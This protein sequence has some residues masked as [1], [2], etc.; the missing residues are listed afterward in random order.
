MLI[1]IWSKSRMINPIDS[2]VDK[3][4][5]YKVC[6]NIDF[7]TTQA[8]FVIEF[9]PYADTTFLYNLYLIPIRKNLNPNLSKGFI[10]LPCTYTIH[11]NI[12]ILRARRCS[13]QYYLH[14]PKMYKYTF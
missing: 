9:L 8:L 4:D 13:N 12:S 10:E 7:L 6:A 1:R 2:R 14:S 11:H 3:V 5:N